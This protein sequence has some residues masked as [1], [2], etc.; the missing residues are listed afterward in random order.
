MSSLDDKLNEALDDIEHTLYALSS[1]FSDLNENPMVT[2]VYALL[3]D[4]Y[5]DLYNAFAADAE[6]TPNNILGALNLARDRY[7][8]RPNKLTYYTPPWSSDTY[9]YGISRQV[10]KLLTLKKRLELALDAGV[11]DV[12]SEEKEPLTD[13]L[14][15]IPSPCHQTLRLIEIIDRKELAAAMG[16]PSLQ[17]DVLTRPEKHDEALIDEVRVAREPLSVHFGPALYRIFRELPEIHDLVYD[18]LNNYV[19]CLATTARTFYED[20][21]VVSKDDEWGIS[22]EPYWSELYTAASVKR[23]SRAIKEAFSEVDEYL[24]EHYPDRR[25]IR[26]QLQQLRDEEILPAVDRLE[27]L[28]VPSLLQ[29]LNVTVKST[30]DDMDTEEPVIDSALFEDAASPLNEKYWDALLSDHEANAAANPKRGQN[31]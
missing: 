24:E 26:Q 21:N 1:F 13:I 9:T 11:F 17:V 19:L 16:F 5:K 6:L 8:D 10:E 31:G 23:L 25:Q 14:E 28:M 20:Y 22:Y 2:E 7:N 18:G 12:V 27:K 30:S 29:S 15:T 3:E 4:D